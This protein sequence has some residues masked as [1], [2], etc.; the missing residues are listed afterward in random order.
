MFLSLLRRAL[1][2]GGTEP[3]RPYIHTLK[4]E[5]QHTELLS[6]TARPPQI[7]RNQLQP[8]WAPLSVKSL[9]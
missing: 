5:P 9:A 1:P 8:P 4:R 7:Q 3:E 2:S 6:H